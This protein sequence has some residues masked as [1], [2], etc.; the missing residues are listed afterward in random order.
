LSHEKQ[1]TRGPWK[2]FPD[3]SVCGVYTVNAKETIFAD[4]DEANARLIAAAPDMLIALLEC[5][6]LVLEYPVVLRQV[7]AA[8]AKAL[9]E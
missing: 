9:G 4:A 8:I 7:K 1:Y 2:V 6:V 3:D 5:E